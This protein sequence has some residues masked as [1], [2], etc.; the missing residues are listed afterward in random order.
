MNAQAPTM[1]PVVVF[2]ALGNRLRWQLMRLMADGRM[3]SATQAAS[4]L[5]RDVDGVIKHFRVLRDAGLVTWTTS[6]KD[7][8]FLMYYIP[9]RFRPRPGVLDYGVCVVNI[10]PLIM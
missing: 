4:E 7:A 10:T 8:R 6:Q 3:I 5:N 1:N 2:A 9:D